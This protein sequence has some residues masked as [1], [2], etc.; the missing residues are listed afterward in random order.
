MADA[1][2]TN[3]ADTKPEVGASED[4]WGTKLNG[5]FDR[6]DDRDYRLLTTANYALNGGTADALTATLNPVWQSLAA[7]QRAYVKVSADNTAGVTLA[8]DSTGVKNVLNMDGSTLTA[9]TLKSGGV[10]GFIYD[11]TQYRLLDLPKATAA[12]ALTGTDAYKALTAASLAGNISK[13]SNGYAKLP[14][15]LTFIWGRSGT[16][17]ADTTSGAITFHTA[18]STACFQVQVTANV[19]GAFPSGASGLGHAVT[20]KSATGCT[21][22]ND[23]YATT[24]DYFAVGY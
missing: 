19:G 1:T 11:G 20:A 24:F 4:S 8:V 13:L 18:F 14:G 10:Y 6:Y 2:T 16:I 9:G 17:A 23:G 7:G 5:N 3:F 12:E 21:V 22:H 15:G